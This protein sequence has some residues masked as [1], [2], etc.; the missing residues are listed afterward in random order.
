MLEQEAREKADRVRTWFRIDVVQLVHIVLTEYNDQV[1]FLKHGP[2]EPRYEK[3]LNYCHSKFRTLLFLFGRSFEGMLAKVERSGEVMFARAAFDW[4]LKGME[5]F[6]IDY[7]AGGLAIGD[8][9]LDGYPYSILGDKMEVDGVEYDYEYINYK[10]RICRLLCCG[11]GY[12]TVW[13]GCKKWTIDWSHAEGCDEYPVRK[14][15][16]KYVAKLRCPSKSL[17]SSLDRYK[18]RAK[19][20][21]I[22]LFDGY[23]VMGFAD[24]RTN[25]FYPIRFIEHFLRFAFTPQ[26]IVDRIAHGLVDQL[27]IAF[28]D[29]WES[30]MVR[31]CFNRI[32]IEYYFTQYPKDVE[33]WKI[34][35]RLKELLNGE[36]LDGKLVCS[37]RKDG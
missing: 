33:Y 14:L 16:D 32:S 7:E 35:D 3:F 21:R 12:D 10:G 13:Q 31:K 23:S 18:Y 11:V 27:C 6:F 26:E 37:D 15:V 9:F 4:Y 25:I 24:F 34:R 5:Q 30:F 29:D 2:F 36:R 20:A 19:E 17:G 22:P 28:E 1:L 8:L